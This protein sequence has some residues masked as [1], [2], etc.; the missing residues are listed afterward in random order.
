MKRRKKRPSEIVGHTPIPGYVN[1]RQ[2]AAYLGVGLSRLAQLMT[3]YGVRKER[4]TGNSL[5][6]SDAE[7][8]KIPLNRPS[9]IHLSRLPRKK[10]RRKTLQK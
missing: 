8:S 9:G 2:A 6:I 10:S 7:L 4:P 5:M 1:T 3:Q